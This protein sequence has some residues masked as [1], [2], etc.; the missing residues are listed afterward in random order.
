VAK[1]RKEHI[2]GT[3]I[4]EHTA[5]NFQLCTRAKKMSDGAQIYHDGT[6]LLN[7]ECFVTIDGT[8]H[9]FQLGRINESVRIQIGRIEEKFH[10]AAKITVHFWVVLAQ[11]SQFVPSARITGED[12]RGEAQR[13]ER[14]NQ[15]IKTVV[16]GTASDTL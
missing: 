8:Q 9:G 10:D 4:R 13:Y 6:N 7:C 16:K 11:L 3:H 12:A 1:L 2:F 14:G 15:D 5:R